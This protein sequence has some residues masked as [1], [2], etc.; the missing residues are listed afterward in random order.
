MQKQENKNLRQS[1][2]D[3]EQIANWFEQQKEIDVELGIKKAK[4][5]AELLKTTKKQLE[6]IENE[7]REIKESIDRD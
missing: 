6:E 1:M 5:G 7:F 3:L 2:K 4:E